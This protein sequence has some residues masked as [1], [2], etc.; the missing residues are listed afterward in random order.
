M[1]PK[2]NLIEFVKAALSSQEVQN[3]LISQKLLPLAPTENGLHPHINV[4]QIIAVLKLVC[5]GAEVA[6]P[7]IQN[8]P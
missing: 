3:Y 7:V 8:L 2:L 1:E 6:C 4:E 5:D